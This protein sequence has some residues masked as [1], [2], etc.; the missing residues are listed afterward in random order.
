MDNAIIIYPNN[1]EETN[2]YK[3]LAK[4]LNNK[5]VAKKDLV[6][7]KEKKFLDDLSESI[8]EMRLHEQGK[9][10]LK[11]AKEVLDEL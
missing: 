9:I 4:R 1:K 7:A 5:F 10:Q 2:L 6:S 3:Q 11:S 8:H